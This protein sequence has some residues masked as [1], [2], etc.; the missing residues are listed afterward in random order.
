MEKTGTSKVM[1]W[2]SLYSLY[3]LSSASSGV[4]GSAPTPI[5]QRNSIWG[6]FQRLKVMPVGVHSAVGSGATAQSKENTVVQ[7]F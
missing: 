3:P 2:V 7:L 1:L 6:L 4:R 5:S